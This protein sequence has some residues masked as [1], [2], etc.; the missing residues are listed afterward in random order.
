M[1]SPMLANVDAIFFS[2]QPGFPNSRNSKV[3]ALVQMA[4]DLDELRIDPA[5]QSRYSLTLNIQNSAGGFDDRL[6]ILIF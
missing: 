3:L 2:N 6:I 1:G 4:H 5:L